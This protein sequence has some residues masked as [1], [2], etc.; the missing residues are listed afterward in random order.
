MKVLVVT[1]V[2]PPRTGGSGR[3]LWELYRR[4]SPTAVSIVA[5]AVADAGDFDR[6]ATP[7]I[8]RMPL[9]FGGVGVLSVD[10]ARQ[11]WRAY[12]QLRRA[13]TRQRAT[14]LHCG[15]CLPEGLLALAIKWTMGVPF[16]CYVH[17]EELGLART[18][19][20][21]NYF[22]KKVLHS[23]Q[24]VI[25]NSRHSKALLT[26]EWAVPADKIVVMHPGVDVDRFV[27]A[28][29][30][31][32]VRAR[33]GWTGR[34]VILTVGALQKRKGQDMMIRALPAVKRACPDVLYA[35]SGE[36]WERPA[37]EQLAREHG[38]EDAIQF[39]GVASEA[40]LHAAL[41]QCDLFALP[42]RRV[43]WDFEGFGIALIEAQASGRPVIAG[44]DGGA[45]ETLVNGQTGL[46]VD[47]T[48]P[49]PLADA[50]IALLNNWQQ[51]QDMG[52][53]GREWVVR[54]FAW[55]ALA[56]QAAAQFGVPLGPR[57]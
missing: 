43:G 4:L 14:V 42:N 54:Q 29:P 7:T 44:N 13:V 22:S 12:W 33:F 2:F 45:P 28:A 10:G 27:P 26:T 6:G 52:R 23:S 1:Q 9:D 16:V 57:L 38:V 49:E 21:L 40:D 25:A 3:W 17:G 8:E 19:R 15:K 5:G 32:Q 20:E 48:A 55:T 18:S 56:G 46:V 31:A 35:M 50:V 34:R 39:L 41:Q 53:A 47:C 37:L 51:R 24:A 11:Y 36:G 30:S